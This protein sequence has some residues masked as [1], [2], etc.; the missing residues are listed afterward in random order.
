MRKNAQHVGLLI[1]SILL[2]NSLPAVAINGTPSWFLS[3]VS[4]VSPGSYASTPALAFDH[5]GTPAIAWSTIDQLGGPN[6]VRES[7]LL[8]LGTWNHRTLASATNIGLRTSLSFDRAERPAIAW[9]NSDGSVQGQFNYGSNLSVAAAGAAN[10]T[11]RTIDL[12]YD[13]AG[14]LRGMYSGTTA[15]QFSSIAHNGTT[16]SA[17]SMLSLTG[18]TAIRDASMITNDSGLR[19]LVARA[20][21]SA[22]GQG[23]I[24][25]SE[26][27]GGG[28]WS[29]SV[30][31]SAD[32]VTGVDITRDPTDGRV[33][34]A[35]STINNTSG[36]SKL[37]YSKFNGFVMQTT[38]L[39]SSTANRYEDVSIAFDFSDGKP[40]IAYE[41]KIVATSTEQLLFAYQDVNSTWQHSL[42]DSTISFDAPNNHSRKPS[43]AFDDFGTSWPA[44]AYIDG[45]GSLTT[46]F[47][48]P[49]P[50]PA[51][52][53]LCL[54]A[55]LLLGR[56]PK[57]M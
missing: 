7:Q 35:Y 8:G 1:S 36:L 28:T 33:A 49:A 45:D 4:T 17:T 46:A 31:A 26:P 41:R 2:L 53:L 6:I 22:G 12:S 37:F 56:R 40:A 38:E 10:P 57:R 9:T 39:L 21:L 25:A 11:F 43:L 23:V 3:S 52:G 32:G 13:L 34:L 27:A 44:I 30:L 48:P 50:E 55:A 54:A 14:N 29:S 24:I 15:G 16:F 18:I 19:Q 20:D 5:Y 51:T 42:V 47:D